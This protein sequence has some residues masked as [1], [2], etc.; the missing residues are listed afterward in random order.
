LTKAAIEK[1]TFLKLTHYRS[2]YPLAG[3]ID[4]QVKTTEGAFLNGGNLGKWPSNRGLI[5]K[6]RP[7]NGC[8]RDA[9]PWAVEWWYDFPEFGRHLGNVD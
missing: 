8:G 2:F 7:S 9:V 6:I 1:R 4:G 3:E 5:S